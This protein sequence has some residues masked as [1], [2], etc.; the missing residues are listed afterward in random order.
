MGHLLATRPRG[1]YGLALRAGTPDHSV[2]GRHTRPTVR[3]AAAAATP[4]RR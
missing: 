1:V 2:F 3:P 4:W